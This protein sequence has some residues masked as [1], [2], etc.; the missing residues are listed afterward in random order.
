MT[1]FLIKF[2]GFF[3]IYI[4]CGIARNEESKIELFS[5]NWF[6]QV[7]LVTIGVLIILQNK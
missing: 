3:L 5:L 7:F 1:D 2:F 4:A 6:I